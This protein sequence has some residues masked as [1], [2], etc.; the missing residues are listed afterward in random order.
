MTVIL[1]EMKEY[2]TVEWFIINRNTILDFFF[3][4]GICHAASSDESEINGRPQLNK[5][6]STPA[7]LPTTVVAH[8]HHIRDYPFFLFCFRWSLL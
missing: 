5:P 6:V 4:I 2:N 7:P 3:S 8:T 1:S